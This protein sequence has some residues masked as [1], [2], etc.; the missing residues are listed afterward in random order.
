TGGGAGVQRARW[1]AAHRRR[2]GR[3]LRRLPRDAAHRRAADRVAVARVTAETAW[4]LILGASLGLGLWMLVSVVPILRRPMLLHRV[5]PYVLD[6]SAGAR[7]LVAR[8]RV[9]PTRVLGVVASPVGDRLAPV[10]HAV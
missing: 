1:P 3:D 4:S 10:V 8:R 9:N 2:R 5:A 7:D 6:V